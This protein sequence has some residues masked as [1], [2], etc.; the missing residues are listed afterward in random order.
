MQA[1]I[2]LIVDETQERVTIRLSAHSYVD[3]V[4]YN[5]AKLKSCIPVRYAVYP[6]IT[7][8]LPL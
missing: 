5:G 4:F 7:P 6:W 1:L 3:A 8:G 2:E